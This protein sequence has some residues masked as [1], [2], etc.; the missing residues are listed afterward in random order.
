MTKEK[1]I[2]VQN[3]WAEGIIEMGKLSNDR[4]VYNDYER[5][6]KKYDIFQDMDTATDMKQ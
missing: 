2:S 3:Q 1:I 4:Y 6:W 5:L